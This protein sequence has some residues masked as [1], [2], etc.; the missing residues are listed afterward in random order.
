MSRIA[1]PEN[2][3]KDPGLADFLP[4]KLLD[5]LTTAILVLGPQAQIRYLNAAAENLL[6][7]SAAFGVGRTLSDTLHGASALLLDTLSDKEDKAATTI[8]DLRLSPVGRSDLE[9]LVDCTVSRLA[10]TNRL[11]ELVDKTAQH[12]RIRDAQLLSQVGGS[13]LMVRSLAHEIKNPLGG[14]RGAAQLLAREL[15]DE[16]LQ[17]YTQVIIRE[18]DRLAAL[19]DRLLGPV[20]PSNRALLNLHEPI[21]HV[22]RLLQADAPTPLSLTRDYDPSLPALPADRDQMIQVFLNLGRN[23][24][25]AMGPH[26]RLRVRTRALSRVTI[27][28]VLHRM[29]A[30]VSFEDDGPGVPEALVDSLFY[31]L[32]TGRPNG[33]GLGLAVAQE[34]VTRHHGLIEFESRPGST[35]FTVLLPYGDRGD[36]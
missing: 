26:G 34:L 10:C 2:Q 29:V 11:V 12:R 36:E 9:I 18:A 33:S 30:S 23:A 4:P 16:E 14:L 5:S 19:V 15:A 7:V 35:V 17:E 22:L 25:Q 27:G 8:R 24:V 20:A 21:E 28:A 31:P 32:V 3:V 13:R 6:G 1:Q